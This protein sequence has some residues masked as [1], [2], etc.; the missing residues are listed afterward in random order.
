MAAKDRG[1]DLTH[2]VAAKL[3]N[4]YL[5]ATFVSADHQDSPRVRAIHPPIDSILLDS[6]YEQ[7]YGTP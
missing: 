5:K 4:I 6:L 3:I 7:P 1:L 2:G